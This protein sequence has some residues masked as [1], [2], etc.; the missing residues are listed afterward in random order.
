MAQLV[1][2]DARRWHWQMLATILVAAIFLRVVALDAQGLWTDEAF[3]I[4]LSNWSVSDMLL[5]PTD[6]TPALYYIIHKLLIPANASLEAIRS[7]SVLAG[8]LSVGLIYVL[9]RLAFGAAGGLLAAALLAVWGAHVDYSQEA[10]AYSLLFLLTLLTSVGLIHYASIL[11]RM[12]DHGEASSRWRRYFALALF[13]LGNILSFYTHLVAVFWI[14]LTSLLLV[15]AARREW[16]V[17]WPELL[18]ALGIM[19]AGAAPGLYRFV[20]QMQAGDQFHWLPQADLPE[21]ADVSATVFLPLGLWVNP[22]TRALGT[23]G[24][25]EAVVAAVAMTLLL[26]GCWFGRRKLVS[27]AQGQPVVLWLI[28]AYLMVPALL[29]LFGFALRPIFMDRTALFAVP[30][31]ILL[32]TAV[33][34]SLERRATAVAA[35]GTVLLYCGS[36]L[37]FGIVREKEDWRGA[38]AYLASA[39]AP[40]DVIAICPLYNYP[41]LRYH[42]ASPVGSAVLGKARDGRLLVVEEGLGTNPNWD[43]TYF[44]HV[45]APG[46]TGVP[47][48]RPDV[49]PG[50]LTLQPG[51]SI[52]RVNGHCN[53]TFSADLDKV[54][55]VVSPDP[56]VA[57]SYEPRDPRTLGITI[58][59]YRVVAPVAIEVRDIV[60]PPVGPSAVL[61]STIAP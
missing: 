26:A 32:I 23:E 43:K 47:V 4:V 46:T 24:N 14:A 49:A 7:I 42:A 18:A 57:W 37:L 21:F 51:Q 36:T 22:L 13:C 11:H 17:Y 29:W 15:S 25:A 39:A 31:M 59:R 53:P 5:L 41:A 38:Y 20:Q 27:A 56:G 33:C 40:T 55:S 6:P 54:L 45:W 52:W 28:L 44:R 16:R 61:S 34:L 1:K 9:G 58:R 60:A 10:R 8:I 35:L 19:A 30:G 50:Y 48:A 12:A 3:T 2:R